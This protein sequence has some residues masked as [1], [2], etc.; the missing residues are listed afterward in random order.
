MEGQVVM[1]VRVRQAPFPSWRVWRVAVRR[2][3][4]TP[5]ASCPLC[6]GQRAIFEPFNGGLIPVVCDECF[7]T[8]QVW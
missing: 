2:V 1:P 7:G 4:Q 5:R 6:W 3:T 8:G